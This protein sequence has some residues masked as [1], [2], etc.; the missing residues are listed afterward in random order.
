MG[1]HRLN[2]LRG[3][4]AGYVVLAHVLENMGVGSEYILIELFKQGQVAV[5]LF[6]LLSGFV[7]HYNYF[8]KEFSFITYLIKRFRRIYPIFLISIFISFLIA[9]YF[10]ILQERSLFDLVGNILNMQDLE[11]MA[12]T[13]VRTYFNPP[14]W[15]LSYE[16][17]FY[18]IYLPVIWVSR[19]RGVSIYNIS[20]ALSLVGFLVY[21][22]YPNKFSLNFIYL[23]IWST[24]AEIAEGYLLCKKYLKKKFFKH[25]LVF[26]FF[27]LVF[28]AL[29]LIDLDYNNLG[30][31][32]WLRISQ[33]FF[34]CF[35]LVSIAY[36]WQ[37]A[38][39]LFFDK[40]FKVFNI[41]APFSFALYVIHR[42]IIILV[43]RNYGD[44]KLDFVEMLC[45]LSI[46]VVIAWALEVKLQPLIDQYS[47][48]FIKK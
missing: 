21:L 30:K 6:F 12:G 47:K 5:M 7:I 29:Y 23:I 38:N 1:L 45:S 36:F 42:P 28:I 27:S 41:I 10:N 4:A 8:E 17:F 31:L 46:A 37:K 9:W 18:L 44:K 32:Y 43:F 20:L 35:G 3:F 40:I 39:W 15:S 34:M 26:L 2:Y 16:W 33:H 19:K 25:V 24:G 14:L 22:F 11:V 13:D 48:R